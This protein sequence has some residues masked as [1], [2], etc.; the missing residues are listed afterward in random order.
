MSVNLIAEEVYCNHSEQ[1]Q[2]K[3]VSRENIPIFYEL[4]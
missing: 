1:L 4:E 3:A 2:L